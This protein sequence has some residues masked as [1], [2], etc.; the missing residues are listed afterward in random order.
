MT[1]DELH[2]MLAKRNEKEL[3]TDP[4]EH[5]TVT[6][7]KTDDWRS[8]PTAC[9]QDIDEQLAH[10]PTGKAVFYLVR[11][12]DKEALRLLV[13]LIRCRTWNVPPFDAG[14]QE[15]AALEHL[16]DTIRK[17]AANNPSPA[18]V[19]RP[20]HDGAF[21]Y[22]PNEVRN[23]FIDDARKASAKKRGGDGKH[24][25]IFDRLSGDGD[26][27][28]RLHD[29]AE[30]EAQ[31]QPAR[32]TYIKKRSTKCGTASRRPFAGRKSRPVQ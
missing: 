12:N 3:A 4:V 1:L 15:S 8:Q 30:G 2:E 24:M 31:W 19:L 13:K 27:E 5:L 18:V 10:C 32:D 26:V 6:T 14:D 22:V 20:A 25:P 23:R 17:K 29:D 21:E 16:W 7:P 11:H 9:D 28:R